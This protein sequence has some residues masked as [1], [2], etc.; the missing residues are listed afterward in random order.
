MKTAIDAMKLMANLTMTVKVKRI[1]EWRVRMKVAVWLIWLATKIA[2][3]GLRV[4]D[5]LF[6]QS[7][8]NG[9]Q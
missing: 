3:M 7:Q 8:S 2:G 6:I 1:P 9:D 4:E 5:E